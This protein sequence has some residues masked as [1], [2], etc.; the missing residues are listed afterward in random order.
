MKPNYL[1]LMERM[2]TLQFRLDDAHLRFGA[3]LP[4]RDIRGAPPPALARL[5]LLDRARW[6]WL[7]CTSRSHIQAM[8][9]HELP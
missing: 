7:R 5:A 6:L 1:R 2:D 9:L 3:P 4:A 8:P